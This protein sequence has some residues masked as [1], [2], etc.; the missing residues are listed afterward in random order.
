MDKR[1]PFWL[2]HIMYNLRGGFLVRPLII[3]LSLGF[4]GAFL[5]WLEEAFREWAILCRRLFSRP[6]ADPQ[7]AQVILR[8]RLLHHDGG[9]HRFRDP[10]DDAHAGVHAVFAADHRQLRQGPRDAMDARRFPGHLLLL[11]G[12]AA[13]RAIA[14]ASVCA[15]ITVFGAMLLGLACVAWL[16]YFIHHISQAISVSHIVDRIALETEASSTTSCRCRA[17]TRPRRK[18]RRRELSTWDVPL[19]SQVSGYI[20]FI[21]TGRSGQPWRNSIM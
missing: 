6:T 11:H 10:A 18:A 20:R 9:F 14:S 21:D 15:G 7:V 8:D 1:L 5:S 17:E 2:R 12:R 16:L 3:A 4:A 19:L 13:D